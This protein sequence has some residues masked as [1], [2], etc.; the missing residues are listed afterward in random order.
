MGPA[1]GGSGLAALNYSRYY[2]ELRPAVP[3]RN[4]LSGIH[5]HNV[6]TNGG[7][8]A[9]WYRG[10]FCLCAAAAA[11]VVWAGGW[12]VGGGG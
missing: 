1:S 2:E 8:L 4:P 9:S 7:W 10:A 6:Q 3:W 5:L 11:A 12:G